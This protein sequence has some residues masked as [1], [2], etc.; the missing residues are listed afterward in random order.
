MSLTPFNVTMY[1]L[2]SDNT[3]EIQVFSAPIPE[4]SELIE[5]LLKTTRKIRE[6]SFK[7]YYYFER[8]GKKE[9]TMF[10]KYKIGLPIIYISPD[11]GKNDNE[12][13]F[14]GPM[15]ITSITPRLEKERTLEHTFDTII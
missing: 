15:P 13:I 10:E 7:D 4:T 8:K 2:I 12:E 9:L 11:E 6:F 3:G 1:Y 14:E 5:K